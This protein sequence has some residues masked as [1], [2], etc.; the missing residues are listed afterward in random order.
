MVVPKLTNHNDVLWPLF[1]RKVMKEKFI[2]YHTGSA[3]N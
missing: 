2:V 3:Q 1:E